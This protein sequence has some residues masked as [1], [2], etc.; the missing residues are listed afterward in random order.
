MESFDPLSSAREETKTAGFASPAKHIASPTKGIDQ[1]PASSMD[2]TE[3]NVIEKRKADDEA[4]MAK[5]TEAAR[6]RAG[7]SIPTEEESI[8]EDISVEVPS[9]SEE[10]DD[11]IF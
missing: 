11:I 4:I 7:Q 2:E 9:G 3:F 6:N 5:Y 8:E 10:G 1:T